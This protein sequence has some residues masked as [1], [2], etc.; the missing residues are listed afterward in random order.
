MN[1]YI[2]QKLYATKKS[3]TTLMI[4]LLIQV[5]VDLPATINYHAESDLATTFVLKNLV[6]FASKEKKIKI[7]I[8]SKKHKRSS[9][10]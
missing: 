9:T 1:S 3:K 5:S 2:K 10:I 4:N 8:L 6:L 7:K